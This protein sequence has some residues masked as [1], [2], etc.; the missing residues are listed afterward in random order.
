MRA[1][2]GLVLAVLSVCR[3]WCAAQAPPLV[4]QPLVPSP[5]LVAPPPSSGV[6]VPQPL[7]GLPAPAGAVL[8]VKAGGVL[9]SAAAGQG[10]AAGGAEAVAR[11]AV[12]RQ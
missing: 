7:L 6:A 3:E 9:A 4:A 5:G 12:F 8:F 1:R 11:L 10:G 2:Y